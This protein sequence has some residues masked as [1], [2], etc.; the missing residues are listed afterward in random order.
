MKKGIVGLMMVMCIVFAMAFNVNACH[1]ERVDLTADC[2]GYCISGVVNSSNIYHPYTTLVYTLSLNG[3]PV[4][5]GQMVLETNP[6]T[7]LVPFERCGI[8]D[9]VPCGDVIVEGTASLYYSWGDLADSASLGP[10]VLY[11]PCDEGEGCTPGYWRNHRNAWP[12]TGYAWGDDFDTT[13][14]VDLFT[15]NITLGQAIWLGGGGK[16]KVAR[17]ATAALLN[18]AHPDV[19][20]KYT[21]AEVIAVV[22]AYPR[23]SGDGLDIDDLADANEEGCPLN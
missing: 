3:M 12:P 22:Q 2:E 11:C 10:K 1:F 19:D 20:Y 13:F 14:G 21:A 17:H 8:W 6:D 18:A 23:P 9:E 7:D 15:P 5:S 4:A 16:R